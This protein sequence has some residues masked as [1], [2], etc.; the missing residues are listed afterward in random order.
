MPLRG[1]C[2]IS[3]TQEAAQ[4]HNVRA[5]GRLLSRFEFAARL[6]S[7]GNAFESRVGRRTNGCNGRQADDDDQCQHDCVF[8]SRGAVFG[9]QKLFDAL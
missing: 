2:S 8:D 5:T 4:F 3:E 6:Q 7:C 1:I 9:N